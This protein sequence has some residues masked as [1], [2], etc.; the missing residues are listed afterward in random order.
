MPQ[1]TNAVAKSCA[2]VMFSIESDCTPWTD[3]SGSVNAIPAPAQTKM[4]GEEYTFDGDGALV[5]VGKMEPFDITVRIVYTETAGEAYLLERTQFLLGACAGRICLY[6][7]P[8]GGNVGDAEYVTNYAPITSHQWPGVEAGA[9]GPIMA[10]FTLRVS[11]VTPSIS[12]S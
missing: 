5:E 7:S 4:V 6:W 11:T 10:E 2:K 1:T 3:V 8:N 9:A 12:A